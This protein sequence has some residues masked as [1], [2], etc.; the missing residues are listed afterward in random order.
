MATSAPEGHGKG[1]Q[2][3]P[4]DVRRHGK[5]VRS[6]MDLSLLAVVPY[7]SIEALHLCGLSVWKCGWC[8]ARDRS[9]ASHLEAPAG[10]C[11]GVCRDRSVTKG[12]ALGFYVKGELHL[13][14]EFV[15]GGD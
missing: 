4:E 15:G 8:I 9:M 3:I 14:L 7:G 12:A 6:T 1:D 13:Q 2:C 11:P 5:S 10:Y